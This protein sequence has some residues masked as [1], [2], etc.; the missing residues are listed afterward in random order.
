M[1]KLNR[2]A[3][4]IFKVLLLIMAGILLLL[5]GCVHVLYSEWYQRELQEK[6]LKRFNETQNVKINIDSFSIKFPLKTEINGLSII[7]KGND[8]LVY[9]KRINADIKILPLIKGNLVAN[10]VELSN[11]R[12]RLGNIDST[13]YMMAE[14]SLLNVDDSKFNFVSNEINL[15]KVDIKNG[16]VDLIL[17]KDTIT[18]HVDTIKPSSFNIKVND[19]SLTDFDYNMSLESTID[20]LDAYFKTAK[21]A[22]I[23]LDI[24]TQLISAI[25]FKGECLEVSYVSSV[26][27]ELNEEDVEK[28]SKPWIIAVDTIDLKR[29]KAHYLVAGA[30]PS[31]GVDL[32]N[33]QFDSLDLNVTS[34]YNQG[35]KITI[36]IN[37]FSAKE[38]SGLFLRGNGEFSMD[39][40]VFELG[41]IDV[42]TYNSHIAVA[43]IIGRGDLSD[44]NKDTLHVVGNGYIGVNDI[45]VVCP[46][47]NDYFMGLSDNDNISYDINIGGNFGD[48]DIAQIMID[49]AGRANIM[50]K[51]HVANLSDFNRM[52]GQLDITG[53]IKDA[54]FVNENILDDIDEDFTLPIMAINGNMKM[55]SGQI[56]GDINAQ[57]ENGE[58]ALLA[59]WNNRAEYYDV[60]LEMNKF[61]IDAFFPKFGVSELSG[62]IDAKGR[63][64]NPYDVKMDINACADIKSVKYQGVEYENITAKLRMQEQVA[65]MELLSSN[66]GAD[67]KLNANGKFID[68]KVEWDIDADVQELDL[69]A[70]DLVEQ[71][72][73]AK[74]KVLTS[75]VL[76]NNNK[77][78]RGKLKVEN[79]VLNSDSLNLS[80]EEINSRFMCSDTVT[81]VAFR[82]DD[83]FAFLSISDEI[84]SIGVKIE[85]MSNELNYQIKQ[86]QIDVLK[87][88]QT[89]PHFNLEV[90]SGNNNMLSKY[91]SSKD[92]GYRRLTLSASNDSI[93]SL[94]SKIYNYKSNTTTIDTISITANQFDKI[95]MYNAAIGNKR[96]TLDNFAHAVLS[97]Y[98]ADD[99]ISAQFNQQNIDGI[100]G[101]DIGAVIH[102]GDTIA[103]VELFPEIPKIGYKEWMINDDNYIE[104]NMQTKHIDANVSMINDDSS[105]KIYTEHVDSIGTHQ[106]DVIIKMNDFKLSEWIAI[107]P[108]APPIGGVVSAD[109]KINWGAG[110]LNGKGIISLDDFKYGKDILGSF[111]TD[112]AVSTD[113]SGFMNADVALMID[114]RETMTLTGVLNDSVAKTPLMLDMFMSHFPL[115][116]IN[117]LLP[118]GIASLNGF[119]DGEMKVTGNMLSPIFNGKLGLD[120]ASVLVDVLGTTLVM[121]E[122]SILVEDNI[123]KFKD[124]AI[125]GVN[126]NAL[127]VNGEVDV[128]D[129]ASPRLNL[130]LGATD[131]QIVGSD[132]SNHSNV[133]GK[134]FVDVDAKIKGSLSYLKVDASVDLLGGS[135][136]TYVMPGTTSALSSYDTEDMVKFVKFSDTATVD[137]EKESSMRNMLLDMNVKLLISS[138][139]TIN[140]DL[141]ADG[142][143]KVQLQGNGTFNY[144]INAMQD[145]RFTGRYT[146]NKGFVRYTPPLMSEKLFNFKDGSYLAFNGDILNPTLNISA[147]DEIKA[148]VTQ[149]GQNSRMV[150]FD[151]GLSITN[152]L[153]NMNV[154]FDL[155]TPDDIAIAN[156]LS[157][158]S[159]EQR[160]NQAMNLLLYNVYT[161]SG[162]KSNSNFSGNPL[163][164]FVES[165]L[166]TWAANNV[167]FVDVTFG[168]DQYDKTTD[169]SKSKSTSYSYKVSKTLFNDRFKIVVGGNY[170]TNADVDEEYS[171]NLIND[172][173]FE[174]MLNRSGSMYVKL[175]RQ[176]GCESILEGEI[177]QTGVGFVYKRKLR[178]LKDIFKR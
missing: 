147:V 35:S 12:W 104:Y 62:T 52:D 161:G 146:I 177:V 173:S 148:S 119:L 44:N 72:A 175:F 79:F 3:F 167:G 94:S 110:N 91:L 29:S 164:S 8:T 114:D 50:A 76:D 80:L 163:Y 21:L 31:M 140:V 27:E 100:Q 168:I 68:S 135:N 101:Y 160:A 115:K 111:K 98:I 178:S 54:D 99:L 10:K 128:S 108:Y 20:T 139:S 131:M 84:D 157:S 37:N 34:F 40:E 153:R 5:M 39:E 57:T 105:L 125:E 13:M 9:A 158:M 133:Y 87:I 28:D 61:P 24:T 23:N 60:D 41:N 38:R 69:N 49:L 151:V 22:G 77:L 26:D 48:L 30:T 88:Q 156:E 129:I 90:R 132:K 166:N 16:R 152:T 162:S 92:C 51:G 171:Q 1:F 174:Y 141:S 126:N 81:N 123:V 138:G 18:T 143:N 130:N 149:E 65:T 102:I 2:T 70:F 122:E 73:I 14:I 113:K 6:L 47:Y 67:I 71:S 137:D 109:M 142:K 121:Q 7:E 159:A 118:Q 42:E 107:N 165:T 19:I 95:L 89:L 106:E 55:S 93:I 75:G 112:I 46:K 56:R 170:T 4:N 85:N 116:V 83:L 127:K 15:S 154:V 36:P 96:G 33:I 150:N 86:R 124:F 32:N 53:E 82:N 25:S 155:S 103:R 172:I 117:P 11:A 17:K 43:G 78:L 136:I 63:Q 120:S 59:K 45:K 64:F 97:G 145:T 58:M 66:K 134:G 144:S 176:V 169:G 74:A